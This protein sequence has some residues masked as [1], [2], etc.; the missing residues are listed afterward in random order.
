MK[1]LHGTHSIQPL[2]ITDAVVAE[3]AQI[4]ESKIALT[5]NTT[6]LNDYASAIDQRLS[7]HEATSTDPHGQILTQTTI[8][9]EDIQS[10]PSPV[11]Q[12]I[13]VSNAGDG[14]VLLEIDGDIKADNAT[15]DGDVNISGVTSIGGQTHISGSVVIDGDLTVVG[16]T[17]KVE[18]E[19]IDYDSLLVTPSSATN[20]TGIIVAPDGTGWEDDGST[21]TTTTQIHDDLLY[22]NNGAIAGAQE[23]PNGDLV[24]SLYTRL[25]KTNSDITEIKEIC[26]AV[27]EDEE[28]EY[29]TLGSDGKLFVVTNNW[30]DDTVC[31]TRLDSDLNVISKSEVMINPA[32][33]EAI[34]SGSIYSFDYLDGKFYTAIDEGGLVAYFDEYVMD[35]ATGS[36]A[37]NTFAEPTLYV[38][39]DDLLA[40]DSEIELGYAR[41]FSKTST[42]EVYILIACTEGVYILDSTLNLVSGNIINT[43]SNADQEF[44]RGTGLDTRNN[45]VIVSM[46]ECVFFSFDV[47]PLLEPGADMMT[48]N[49]TTTTLS[50]DFNDTSIA[51]YP[52]GFTGNS[53]ILYYNFDEN[54]FKWID[55]SKFIRF[56]DIDQETGEV[57]EDV[58]T[59]VVVATRESAD[60]HFSSQESTDPVIQ[61]PA[62]HE[63]KMFGAL[64]G[65][66]SV[67]Y[68]S[69]STGFLFRVDTSTNTF[70]STV[71]VNVIDNTPTGNSTIHGEAVSPDGTRYYK[72][73]GQDFAEVA[74]LNT[75]NAV[76]PATVFTTGSVPNAITVRDNNGTLEEIYLA[77][78]Y[79]SNHPEI[80]IYDGDSRELL[81]TI[82]ITI[83]TYYGGIANP[84]CMTISSDNNW[85]YIGS[86]AGS[87]SYDIIAFDLR[88][89]T[90]IGNGSP[91]HKRLSYNHPEAAAGQLSEYI[92]AL[93]VTS[94]GRIIAGTSNCNLLEID[95]TTEEIVSR[96]SLPEVLDAENMSLRSVAV[97]DDYAYVVCSYRPNYNTTSVYKVDIATPGNI[98]NA[99]ITDFIEELPEESEE[100]VEPEEPEEPEEPT[101]EP[102]DII[103]LREVEGGSEPVG[104]TF[105]GNLLELQTRTRGLNEAAVIVDRNGNLNILK[106]DVTIQGNK[107]GVTSNGINFNSDITVPS[108]TTTDKGFIYKAN[109]AATP[110]STVI[111]CKNSSNNNLFT[112]GGNG[113]TSVGGTL[114]LG[115]ASDP[116]YYDGNEYGTQADVAFANNVVTLDDS[117]LTL[118]S[119]NNTPWKIFNAHSS[120]SFYFGVQNAPK[121]EISENEVTIAQTNTSLQ[122]LAVH[123]TSS[124]TGDV[125]VALNATVDGVDIGIHDHSG[126]AGHGERIP[127]TSVIGLQEFLDGHM[128]TVQDY[129]GGMISN[130]TE[131]GIAVTYDDNSGKLNFDVNDFTI[132]AAGDASGSATVSDLGNSTF[133]L[134]VLDSDKVDG[135]HVTSGTV[136][137][138]ANKV[139]KTDANGHTKCGWINTTSGNASTTAMDRVY[140]S[141][142]GYIRYYTPANFA[143]QILALGGT[144]KNSHVHDK[145]NN[146]KPMRGSSTFNGTTGRV[147]MLPAAFANTNYTVAVTPT[148]NTNG[149]LG[150]VWVSKST[151][152]FTVYNTGTATVAFDYIA[153]G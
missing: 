65:A 66:D 44:Y 68:L 153:I 17:T 55:S 112:V 106:G 96:V 100:P 151:D 47:E 98:A 14:N 77:F 32:T 121:L 23:L 120:V 69:D 84:T 102:G 58:D 45:R 67:L 116:I 1:K 78:N 29:I 127:A 90:S 105:L 41:P 63:A 145:V 9:S 139:V 108:V 37:I 24:F 38:T 56:E 80:H 147:V 134:T 122:N 99:E 129:V 73:V 5:Y 148:A 40:S 25:V 7:A 150:D 11:Q 130:N 128:E 19:T 21:T 59:S 133:T 111:S 126:V 152:R 83:D 82:D 119:G 94:D 86:I 64:S 13:T 115:G 107:L 93:A 117:I 132:T 34:S 42:N 15:L 118:A 53:N 110:G 141:Y 125:T 101:E 49:L 31:I 76:F 103:Q 26:E 48:A 3:D 18:S 91:Y 75:G 79:T 52:I 81:K 97:I 88:A 33:G 51:A 27:D 61:P 62:I 142:D 35:D 113:N 4:A 87:T 54:V 144:V 8:R 57:R 104:D 131:S 22:T 28:F 95:E 50:S 74:N 137:N 16:T 123:G 72:S 138:E 36:E 60:S 136:N 143:T 30:D 114:T 149:Q 85:V 124:F 46:G 6:E 89:D 43:G 135:L 39:M 109:S 10:A 140:A 92:E 20:H 71:Y 70:L 146:L 2:T 12:T